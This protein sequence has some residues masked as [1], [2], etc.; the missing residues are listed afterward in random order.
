MGHQIV[1]PASCHQD[2]HMTPMRVLP[3]AFHPRVLGEKTLLFPRGIQNDV[4]LELCVALPSST[5]TVKGLH[6]ARGR[7]RLRSRENTYYGPDSLLKFLTFHI[8]ISSV[9]DR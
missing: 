3:G 8:S 6:S 1:V 5:P 9:L 4:S 7:G 2:E